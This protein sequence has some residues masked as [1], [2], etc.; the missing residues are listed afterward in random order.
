MIPET[1][2]SVYLYIYIHISIN[3]DMRSAVV[4]PTHVGLGIDYWFFA[5]PQNKL[6]EAD[7][8]SVALYKDSAQ[9]ARK[10]WPV[11]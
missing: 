1:E 3:I 7:A 5:L 8:A 11:S 6:L 4:F 9:R 10:A 2:L